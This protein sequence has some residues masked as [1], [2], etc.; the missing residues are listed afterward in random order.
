MS[1]LSTR[2]DAQSNPIQVLYPLSTIKC[3]GPV[4]FRDQLARDIACILDVDDGV[5]SWSCQSQALSKGH[6]THRPDFIVR[7]AE[8]TFLVDAYREEGLPRWA[9][10]SATKEGIAYEVIDRSALPPIRL[11]N[12]KDLLRY[13]RHEA[14]LAD[15]IRLLAALDEF[16]SLP[17]SEALLAFRETKPVAGL[18][19]MVLHGFVSMDLD[20]RLIGPETIVRRPRD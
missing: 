20:E 17:V 12:A 15:R 8:R 9:G 7:R 5:L 13:A 3:V 19:S 4:L 18:A 10:A 14:A 11:K 16:S 2:S 6:Q 1:I